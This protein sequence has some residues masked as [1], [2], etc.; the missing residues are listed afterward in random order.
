M[1]AIKAMKPRIRIMTRSPSRANGRQL[2]SC[3]LLGT[4]GEAFGMGFTPA[5]AYAQWAMH[6]EL[7]EECMEPT[8]S[9]I[10]INR[11]TVW[12]GEAPP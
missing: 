1:T 12:N 4:C 9:V 2:W 6:H 7:I 3:T 8:P 10:R 11:T 5:G